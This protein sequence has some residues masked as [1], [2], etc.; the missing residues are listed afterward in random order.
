MSGEKAPPVG[1]LTDRVQLKRRDSQD[2]G[3]GGHVRIYVPVAH[4]W[5]RVRS[6]TGRQGTNADGRTWMAS[7]FALCLA[8]LPVPLP[9]SHSRPRLSRLARW[10]AGWWR[11]S[12]RPQVRRSRNLPRVV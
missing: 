10:S 9:I 4:L 8:I 6:L 5:A 3:G 12:S 2:D 1:T 7:R 11:T